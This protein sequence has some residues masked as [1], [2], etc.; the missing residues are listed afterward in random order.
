MS[1]TRHA[2]LALAVTALA[3]VVP[4]GAPA[5]TTKQV[6]LEDIEFTPATVTIR[7]GDRV[8]WAWRDPRTPHNVISRGRLRFRSSA[9]KETGTYVVRFRR[10]G[11]YRYVCTIHPG[12]AGKVIVR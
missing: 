12:M 10:R 3:A 11:T 5:A 4:P 8:R 9:I 6:V 7:R 2:A 1:R